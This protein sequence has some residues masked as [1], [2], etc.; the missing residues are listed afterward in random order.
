VLAA[1]PFF[2]LGVYTFHVGSVEI[3]IDPWA[4]LVCIGFVV[5]LEMARS[6][7]VR[8]GLEVRDLVDGAVFVVLSGFLFGH[9]V[10]VLAYHPERLAEEGVMSL[11]KVWEGFSSMGG[12][13]GAVIGAAVFFNYVRP[14]AFWPH[15]DAL[16]WGFPFGW[17][18]GRIGCGTVHDHIGRLTDFPLAMQFPP[19]HFAAG[20]RHELGL[21]EAAYT[22]GMCVLFWVLS[23]KDRPSGYFVALFPILYAP[24]RF[25]L[26]F[27]RNTDLETA[28]A[29]YFGL[30][31]GQYGSIVLF[32]LGLGVWFLVVR[33]PSASTVGAP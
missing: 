11:L 10:T 20:L 9:I 8:L 14:R 21:Y 31:P 19:G 2:E 3:P 28:D 6:R 15:A 33:R 24:V 30:T 1:I 27:L 12:F 16:A 23:R 13:L 4:T 29:R 22:L 32:A 18:F 7:A 26:D 17:L 25:G 5:G